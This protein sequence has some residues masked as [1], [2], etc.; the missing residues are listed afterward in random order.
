M[1]VIKFL[2]LSISLENLYLEK[3]TFRFFEIILFWKCDISYSHTKATFSQLQTHF[4]IFTWERKN[5]RFDF[6][7]VQT[8]SFTQLHYIFVAFCAFKVPNF[9]TTTSDKCE[10]KLQQ[11]LE[12]CVKRYTRNLSE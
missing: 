11:C 5:S 8:F 3:Y 7:L 1:E 10:W 2:K 4:L 9:E 6:E 12:N